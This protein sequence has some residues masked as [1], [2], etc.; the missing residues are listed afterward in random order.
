MGPPVQSILLLGHFCPWIFMW[1]WNHRIELY[2]G[3]AS[4]SSRMES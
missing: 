2:G 4:Y 3:P 1:L